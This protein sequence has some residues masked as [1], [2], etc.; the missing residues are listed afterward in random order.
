[1]DQVGDYPFDGRCIDLDPGQIALY[2]DF[3]GPALE[4]TTDSVK[5]TRNQVCWRHGAALKLAPAAAMRVRLIQQLSDQVGEAVRL[6][7]DLSQELAKRV[8]VPLDVTPAQRADETFDVAER[9]TELV[10]GSTE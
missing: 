3:E 6:V 8:L 10:R 1:V 2:I 7:L 9:Q 5:A 4:L